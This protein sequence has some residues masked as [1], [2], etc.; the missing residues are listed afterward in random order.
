MI[1]R[2]LEPWLTKHG[3]VARWNVMYQQTEFTFRRN[4]QD[5][6]RVIGTIAL[7]P[8]ES[9]GTVREIRELILERATAYIRAVEK[10][11]I[12]NE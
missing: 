2:H 3:M 12:D 8:E 11:E 1:P 5:G 10:G 6:T 7:S 9:S 4:L